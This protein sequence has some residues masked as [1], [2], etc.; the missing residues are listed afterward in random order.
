MSSR[1]SHLAEGIPLPNLSVEKEGALIPSCFALPSGKNYSRKEVTKKGAGERS[2]AGG[3]NLISAQKRDRA[4]CE[5]HHPGP[6]PWRRIKCLRRDDV[7][8]LDLRG[9][10]DLSR[11]PP[12]LPVARARGHLDRELQVVPSEGKEAVAITGR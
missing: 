4:R 10:G 1:K 7:K 8:Q 6:D 5:A 3:T 2:T 9:R 11:K 12:V